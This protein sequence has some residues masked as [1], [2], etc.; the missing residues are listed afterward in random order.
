MSSFFTLLCLSIKTRIGLLGIY[1]RIPFC[2]VL[3][4]HR[5]QHL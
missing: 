4:S 1:P 2:F 5:K 3:V